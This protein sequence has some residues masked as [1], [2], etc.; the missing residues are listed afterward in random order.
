VNSTILGLQPSHAPG[1]CSIMAELL[2]AGGTTYCTQWITNVVCK[3][4][5][6]GSVLDDCKMGTILPFSKGS[7]PELIV[8]IT[9][10]LHCCPYQ[11][12]FLA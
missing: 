8:R 4:W 2:E 7:E 1:I 10:A 3:A 11:A 6:S 9:E 5:E 12:E